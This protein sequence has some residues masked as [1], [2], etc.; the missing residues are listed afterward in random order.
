MNRFK[1]S[2]ISMLSVLLVLLVVAC[3]EEQKN[4]KKSENKP[5]VDAHLA[6]VDQSLKNI[7][8]S[9]TPFPALEGDISKTPDECVKE[10]IKRMSALKMREAAYMIMSPKEYKLFY[11]YS[12]K[13]SAKESDTKF[14]ATMFLASNSKHLPRWSNTLNQMG[15]TE[16]VNIEYAKE[17]KAEIGYDIIRITKIEV[18]DKDGNIKVVEPF[19]SLIKT[20]QGYKVWSVLD[21]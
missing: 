17:V 19:K 8:G 13:G 9:E 14:I 4:E 7:G 16:V 10:V 18:K 5:K 12:M 1:K 21:T 3:D 2:I 15:V 11:P 20:R 6:S